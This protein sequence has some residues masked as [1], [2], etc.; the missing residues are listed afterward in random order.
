MPFAT[1]ILPP[2]IAFWIG[3]IL[4]G[5][6]KIF[7][8]KRSLLDHPNR[9][10]SHSS[11]VPRGGGLAIVI[12]V[13]GYLIVAGI[14]GQLDWNIV[15]GMGGGGLAVA[16]VGWADDI[17]SLSA[18]VRLVV[19]FAAATWAV[20]WIGGFPSLNTGE[21]VVRMG[22]GGSVL[23][24]IG[25]V[26]AINLFNFMDG[27]DG[28]AA[29]ETISIGMLGGVL[30]LLRGDSQWAPLSF[31]LA[32]AALGFLKWNWSPARIFLGDVGSG[33]LGFM[34][35]A[36]AISSERSG[37]V[38]FLVWAILFAAFIV[39]A[40]VTLF[41]RIPRGDWRHA[42]RSHAYQRAVQSGLSHARVSLGFAGFNLFLGLLAVMAVRHPGLTVALL[43][44]AVA[45]GLAM[46]LLIERMEPFNADDVT[47]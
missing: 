47:Q 9:R 39:D 37:S 11:P 5:R 32:A 13:F 38:P 17:R 28:I 12:T 34:I 27:I 15:I 33:F 46:Y 42:H 31:V 4:T 6:I 26:W 1:V 2:I 25:L 45:S 29:I 18:S 41:R 19:H 40:T 36:I 20:Q 14:L 8:E 3:L 21:A 7:A 24:V 44:A 22:F 16:G 35:G 10:S 30:F 43:L 23:A